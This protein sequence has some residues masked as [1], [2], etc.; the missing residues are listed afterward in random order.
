MVVDIESKH[1]VRIGMYLS[2]IHVK[3]YMQTYTNKIKNVI[4]ILLLL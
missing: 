3:E 1:T 4:F 2:H